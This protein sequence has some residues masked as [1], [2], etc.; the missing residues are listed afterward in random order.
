MSNTRHTSPPS[1]SSTP[2]LDIDNVVASPSA[3]IKVLSTPLPCKTCTGC[4]GGTRTHHMRRRQAGCLPRS[5]PLCLYAAV[6]G[7]TWPVAAV[8]VHRKRD[9]CALDQREGERER[10]R[11]AAG[12]TKAARRSSC[13]MPPAYRARCLLCRS[14]CT[15][16]LACRHC[17]CSRQRVLFPSTSEAL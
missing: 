1:L 12:E 17:S 4:C 15:G 14:S 13:V 7:A 2:L 11:T 10:G 9:C 6:Q 5:P 16:R 3:I 8:N